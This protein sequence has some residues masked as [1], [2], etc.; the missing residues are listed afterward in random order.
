MSPITVSGERAPNHHRVILL[1]KRE[2]DPYDPYELAKEEFEI[3][4]Y[5]HSLGH[6]GQNTDVIYFEPRPKKAVAAGSDPEYR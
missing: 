4:Q 1:A 5:T 6:M 2:L 3:R